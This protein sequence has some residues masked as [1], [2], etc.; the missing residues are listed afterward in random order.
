MYI[1]KHTTWGKHYGG[2]HDT[3]V[4]IQKNYSVVIAQAGLSRL[5]YFNDNSQLITSVGSL[6]FR[7]SPTDLCHRCQVDD[8][9]TSY[10]EDCTFKIHPGKL[11]LWLISKWPPGSG[12]ILVHPSKLCYL[13]IITTLDTIHSKLQ[14]TSSYKALPIQAATGP[15][16]CR[17]LRILEVLD[18]RYM[19]VVRIFSTKHWSPYLSVYMTGTNLC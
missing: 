11:L 10:S 3:F 13:L 19:K 16:G 15:W 8:T 17:G 7:R 1:I 5:Y 14:T 9:P 12:R 18:S 2:D 6:L 4:R